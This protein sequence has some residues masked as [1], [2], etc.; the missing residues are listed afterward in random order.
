MKWESKEENEKG[1]CVS[2]PEALVGKTLVEVSPD[3]YR[4][5]DVVNFWGDHTK[6]KV[7]LGWNPNTISF[8]ELVK[9]MVDHDMAKG[10]SEGAAAKAHMN[11][12]EYLENGVVK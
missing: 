5:T 1:I 9:I 8:E 6:A 11:L 7:K 2:G 3:F 4:T 12:A 10:A